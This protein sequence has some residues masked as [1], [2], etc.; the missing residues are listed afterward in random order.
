MITLFLQY[1]Q[2]FTILYDHIKF[3]YSKFIIELDLIEVI[4]QGNRPEGNHEQKED[5]KE[6]NLGISGEKKCG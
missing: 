1:L 2:Y 5:C 3:L 4:V 6:A